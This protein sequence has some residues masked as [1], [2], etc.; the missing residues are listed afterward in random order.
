MVLTFPIHFQNI[1]L[2]SSPIG[3]CFLDSYENTQYSSQV[4]DNSATKQNENDSDEDDH[5]DGQDNETTEAEDWEEENYVE[6]E[7][8]KDNDHQKSNVS[9]SK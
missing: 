9:T 4:S 5:N 1:N 6:N 3:T 8:D 7:K 2:L